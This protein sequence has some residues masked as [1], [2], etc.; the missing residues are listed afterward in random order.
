MKKIILISAIFICTVSYSQKLEFFDGSWQEANDL[1]AKEGKFIMLDAY[2]D[3]CGWCEIMEQQLFTDPEVVPFIKENFVSIKINFEDS[4]GIILAMK[5]RV[6]GYPTL[7]FFNSH[8]QLVNKIFGYMQ[9][10]SK[11]LSEIKNTVEIKKERL[12]AFD[13]HELDLDYPD[14]FKEVFY[15]KKGYKYPSDSAVTAYLDSQKDLFSEVNWSIINKFQT[16]KYKLFFIDHYNEY[17]TMYGQQDV[18]DL[19]TGI[20]YFRVKLAIDSADQTKMDEAMLLCEKLEDSDKHRMFYRMFYYEELKEW[21]AYTNELA[22]YI[23]SEGIARH[24]TINNS[25]W[26]LYENTDN[27]EILSQAIQWMQEVTDAHPTWMYMDTYAALLYKYGNLE[28]AESVAIK[29]IELGKSEDN[30]RVGS[31]EKLLEEIRQAIS[32]GQ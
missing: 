20:I 25:C 26:L 28:K 5:F 14:F 31:T 8:G 30:E 11:F 29:A 15:R 21:K 22:G 32:A 7:L 18:E 13:S 24:S 12:Y 1:A 3:W 23:E 16:A 6:S 4:L 19:L 9:D 10:H 17:K 27:K 2:T